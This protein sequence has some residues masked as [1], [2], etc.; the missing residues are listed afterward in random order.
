MTLPRQLRLTN[1]NN[2]ILH[3]LLIVKKNKTN[4]TQELEWLVS[5]LGNV[6]ELYRV[7]DSKFTHMDF[8]A[9]SAYDLVYMKILSIIPP[10]Q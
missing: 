7:P 5:N 10:A 3:K 9:T 1:F 2:S 6:K 8:I 4:F